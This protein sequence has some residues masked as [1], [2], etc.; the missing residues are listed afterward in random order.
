LRKGDHGEA[1]PITHNAIR[2]WHENPANFPFQHEIAADMA[3]VHAANLTARHAVTLDDDLAY[4]NDQAI[5]AM[6]HSR[7][8]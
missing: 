5:A 4:L 6:Q 3:S 7:F 2:N 8:L 1:K